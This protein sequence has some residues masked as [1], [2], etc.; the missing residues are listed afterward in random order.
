[1][2][3]G[4]GVGVGL[5]DFIV[6]GDADGLAGLKDDESIGVPVSG[7]E[8]REQRRV[9]VLAI[10][11]PSEPVGTLSGVLEVG[12]G[13]ADA[14]VDEGGAV[15]GFHPQLFLFHEELGVVFAIFLAVLVVQLVVAFFSW[16]DVVFIPAWG[17][18]IGT[19]VGLDVLGVSLF[20]AEE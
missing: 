6:G 13:D 16:G 5:D 8:C 10:V 20:V 12:V 17:I 2:K 3:S 11:G 4:L 7:K 9:A 14:E 15:V 1:M 19:G 18:P